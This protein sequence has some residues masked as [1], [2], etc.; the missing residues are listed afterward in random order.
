M[1]RWRDGD[2]SGRA[3]WRDLDRD[4]LV[5]AVLDHAVE[6]EIMQA[7]GRLR[8]VNADPAGPSKRVVLLTGAVTSLH[9]DRLVRLE[10]LAGREPFGRRA[11][12][13]ACAERRAEAEQRAREAAERIRAEGRP[14]TVAAVRGASGVRYEVAR[15]VVGQLLPVIEGVVRQQSYVDI[16]DTSR[17]TPSIEQIDVTE[18]A[19]ARAEDTPAQ[20]AAEAP[21]T[22]LAVSVAHW[23]EERCRRTT[24]WSASLSALLADYQQWAGAERVDACAFA[25]AMEEAGARVY[26][27]AI[28]TGLVLR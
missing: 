12:P 6:A 9:I 15:T 2:G 17:T 1:Y 13:S 26:G 5:Q 21:I 23:A 3:R 25:A 22:G 4:V 20:G 14:L 8:A 28:V 18:S 7:V 27:T 11:M 19:E 16:D 10:E 24:E